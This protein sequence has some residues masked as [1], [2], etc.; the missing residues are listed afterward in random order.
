[1]INLV[2]GDILNAKENIISQQVNC[3]GVMGSGLAKQIR[4]KYLEVFIEYYAYCKRHDDML[5][6]LGVA[7][8]VICEDNKIVMNLFGQ[9][10]YGTD[11]QYTD[12]AALECAFRNMKEYAQKNQLSIAI[13][14]QI[15]CGLAG[16][17]W[18]IVYKII[19]DVFSDYGV[20]IYK[21]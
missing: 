13:P 12:Y 7:L 17:N 5:K 10:Y 9:M 16:G 20:T 3:C 11:K 4:N 8:P 1:M 15:G 14:F 19:E 18:D 6:M 21:L 2:K